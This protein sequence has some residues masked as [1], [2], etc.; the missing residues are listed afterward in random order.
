M[1]REAEAFGDFPLRLRFE[2]QLRNLELF[3]EK[4]NSR[5]AQIA[6][7]TRCGFQTLN[8]LLTNDARE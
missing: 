5:F 2:H 7:Q 8:S 3:S 1:E 4:L 6:L